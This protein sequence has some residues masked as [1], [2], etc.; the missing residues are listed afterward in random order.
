MNSKTW[1]S[2][3]ALTLFG[4]LV[5]PVSLAAQGQSKKTQPHQYHH[6]QIVDVGTFGGPQ[7]WLFNPGW[8][9]AGV[10]NNQGALAGWADTSEVDPYCLDYPDCNTFHAY[11]SQNGVTTDLGVLSGGI[12]SQVDWISANGLMAGIGDNGQQDPLNPALPQVHG[13]LWDHGVVTDLGNIGGGYNSFALGVNNR[14][15]VVGQ[16]YNTVPDANSIFGYGYQS[17]AFYWHN[18]VMQDLGTL[19]TGTDAMAVLI[20]QR[21]HVVGWS[22]TNSAPSSACTNNSPFTLTTG[23]FIW[24]KKN[25]MKDIGGLGGTCTLAWDLNNYGQIVGASFLTGDSTIHPFVWN[26]ATGITDLMD[27]ADTGYGLAFAENAHGDVAGKA[28]D[29]LTCYAVLW[30]KSGGHWQRIDL[31]TSTQSAASVSVN[32]SDQVIGNFVLSTGQ[33][34]FLSEDGGPIVDLNTLVPPNSGVLLVEA[35]QIND[36]G[37]IA[38]GTFDASGNNHAVLLVPCDDNHPGVV[39]CDYSPADA[40][41]LAP[42][43]APRFLPDAIQPSRPSLPTNRFHFH[44]HAVVGGAAGIVPQVPPVPDFTRPPVFLVS[45]TSQ[46]TPGSVSPGGS[47]TITVWAG[48]SGGSSSNGTAAL[49]CSVQPSPPLAPTCSINP[50]SLSFPGTATLTVSTF[51]PSG[52]LLSRPGSGLLYALWLPLIGLVATGSGLGT[53][54]NEQKRRLKVAA[55][56]CALFAGL[57]LQVAC[58]GSGSSG[59]P[60]GTYTINVN[61]TAVGWVTPTS[62]SNLTTLTVQ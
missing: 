20:N 10:L 39:G 30:R 60:A 15:E 5:L 31:S 22:Y 28:C 54:R 4:E 53:R 44:G 46:F 48:F 40:G 25:G 11:L 2:I 51:G 49:S 62:A 45:F 47:S 3:I 14:G 32:S 23:T 38:I 42:S 43:A 19:G 61:A 21:G 6:Y 52:R 55:L 12:G 16:A 57:T 29:S 8:S 13:I 27:P 9:R 33:Y 1:T 36:R 18:G 26:A 37:E 35:V 50:A 58:G 59:T 7:S 24:D 41:T 17:R 56:A 34:A